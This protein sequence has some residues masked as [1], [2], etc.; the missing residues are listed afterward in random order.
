MT[1][2]PDE[3]A[4]QAPSWRYDSRYKDG[5]LEG[6]RAALAHREREVREL[7]LEIEEYQE[8][9]DPS[10]IRSVWLDSNGNWRPKGERGAELL[11]E[12]EGKG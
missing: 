5:W 3:L 12:E 7:E 10:D 6:A 2:L 4:K 8:W 1:D 11:K 9:I